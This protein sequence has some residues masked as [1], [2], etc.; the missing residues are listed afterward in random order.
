MLTDIQIKSLKPKDKSYKVSDSGGL[1]I[2]VAK[3]G[4]KLW[5][6]K[7][8][9]NGKEKRIALGVYPE[10]SLKEA[11]AKHLTARKDV[12][13]QIDPLEKRKVE[14]ITRS[15][16]AE[17]SF[18]AVALEW[19]T[20]FKRKWSTG[21]AAK[22][23]TRLENDIFPWIGTTPIKD[24]EPPLIL[25][26]IQRIENR[27]AIDSAHRTMQTCGQIFRYAVATSRAERDPTRDLKGA[28]PPVT[29]S[30]FAAITNPD[31][32]APL[33]RD[34]HAYRG[35]LVT[36]NAFKILPY[37]FVRPREL[38]RAEWQEI[39]LDKKQWCIPESKMKM[40]KEHIVPLSNQVVQLLEEL[41]PLT[42]KWDY[43]FP[44]ARSPRR[45]MSENAILA[46]L[47]NLGYDKHTHTP[48]GFRATARTLLDEK[49]EYPIHIIEQQLAHAVKDANGR[50]YNRTAH[51]PQRIE[52]MQAWAD[53]LDDL[54][55]R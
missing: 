25:A 18:K 17:N 36:L 54:R 7:Y 14:K 29:K 31:E 26:T 34:I 55:A 28:I 27:G 43:V 44:G 11:R 12:A 6:Y 37:V 2:E 52:M 3:S 24:I 15:I 20:K 51:L 32:L 5:R 45:P 40:K 49:L 8:R 4:S 9:I 21:H 16:S 39:D 53:Y 47:R 48:H 22:L 46:A 19:H 30:H 50:A 38:R 35:H 10:T 41:K 13:N 42:G 33:L 1:Y 23:L